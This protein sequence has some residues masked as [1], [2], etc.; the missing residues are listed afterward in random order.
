MMVA[1]LDHLRG[2][3]NWVTPQ[4]ELEEYA[5]KFLQNYLPQLPGE[6]KI[7]IV[8]KVVTFFLQFNDCGIPNCYSLYE[9]KQLVQYL[10]LRRRGCA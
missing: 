9:K 3:S 1:D 7:L 2:F 5:T 4:E 8:D 6:V 10:R